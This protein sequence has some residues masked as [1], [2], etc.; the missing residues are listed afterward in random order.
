MIVCESRDIAYLEQGIKHGK[1]IFEGPIHSD[2][3]KKLRHTGRT[4]SIGAT[5]K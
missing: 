1:T 2:F 3:L 4:C 5:L